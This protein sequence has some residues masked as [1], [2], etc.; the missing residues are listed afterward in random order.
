MAYWLALFYVCN[1]LQQYAKN[2][3]IIKIS[4]LKRETQ[5]LKEKDGD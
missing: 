4:S 1:T 2:I 3:Y 5:A